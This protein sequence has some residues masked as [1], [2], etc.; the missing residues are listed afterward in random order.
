[1]ARTATQGTAIAGNLALESVV[2]ALPG[3]TVQAGSP[4]DLIGEVDVTEGATGTAVTLRLR[5][6][7][8]QTGI[9][10]ATFGPVALAAAARTVLGVQWR[11]TQNVDVAGQQYV[12]TM[13]QTGATVNGTANTASLRADY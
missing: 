12:L 11:D 1:V 13:Q 2:L 5:R 10:L 7:A 4:V 8:D 6:G 3:I 9:L